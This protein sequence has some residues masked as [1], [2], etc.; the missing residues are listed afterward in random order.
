MQS[1]LYLHCIIKFAVQGD[2]CLML[3]E[4]VSHPIVKC[5]PIKYV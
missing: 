5:M 3:I 2:D 1:Q 4:L